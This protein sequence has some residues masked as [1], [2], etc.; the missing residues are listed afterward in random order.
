MRLLIMKR[1]APLIA[2]AFVSLITPA[3]AELNVD[4]MVDGLNN[5]WEIVFGPDGDIYFTERDGRIWKIEEF[6]EAKV[7]ETFTKSGSYE[8]G[9]LGLALHPEFEKNKKIYVYQTNLEMEFFQNKVFSFTVDDDML[10]DR[11]IIIDDIPGAL[12]HDGGRIAFGPDG[13]LYITTGD[14]V[15]PGWSQDLSSLAGKILR[16][17]PDGTIPDDNPFDSSPIFSYGHR[18]PQGIAWSNDG[19]LV[20]SEHG[21]SGEMGYGHDEINVI[22]KGK[23]YGWPK[24]VGDSSDVTLVN[25]II[26]S[27]EQT[28]APSG[29]VYF[30]SNKIPSLDGKFLVGALRGQ[31]LMVVDVAEDG[32]LISAEKLFEGDFGRIRT[33]QTGPDGVLYLLTA[34][35]DNDKIIRISESP[36]EEVAKFTSNESGDNL[37]IVYVIVGIV[38][39]GVTVGVIAI[40]RRR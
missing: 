5:P 24:V 33:A 40:K 28:W 22:V 1:F 36:L 38:A 9:T 2:I 27:G 29:M 4:V 12:W 32:S 19:L 10:T 26:H 11:Q 35:G 3:F 20:S 23:N 18:N 16:I 15:N 30:D 7:I 6:G 39:V 14:A 17:N 25:P 21:P 13:K 34:N 31:H 37:T 8:G